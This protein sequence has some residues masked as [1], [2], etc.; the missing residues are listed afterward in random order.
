ML[1]RR[2][3]SDLHTGRESVPGARYFITACTQNRIAGLDRPATRQAIFES[4]T[5]SDANHDTD[6]LALTVM[7]DHMHWLFELGRRL[8]LGRVLARFKTQTGPTRVKEAVTLAWQRDFFEHRL[9]GDEEAEAYALYIFLNPYRAGLIPV[10]AVWPGWLC[11][12]PQ[13]FSFMAKLNPDDTPPPEWIDQPV[14][15]RLRIGE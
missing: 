8:T 13:R 7:P 4:V 12:Q 3:T 1:P 14:P 11:P 2:R 9:Q 6:T 15:L 10:T 5:Q